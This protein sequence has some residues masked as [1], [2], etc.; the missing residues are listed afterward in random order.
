MN[1]FCHH[2]DGR[3]Q[4]IFAFTIEIAHQIMWAPSEKFHEDNKVNM[5]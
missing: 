3:L 4:N 2:L 1:N 5:L